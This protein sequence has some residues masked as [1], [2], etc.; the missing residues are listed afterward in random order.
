MIK[1]KINDKEYLYYVRKHIRNT[2]YISK[3]HSSTLLVNKPK[4]EEPGK[5]VLLF[6]MILNLKFEFSNH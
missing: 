1:E 4:T 6:C 3:N 2:M 5:N